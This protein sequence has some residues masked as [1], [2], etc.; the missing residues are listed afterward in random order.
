M[1]SVNVNAGG[2]VLQRELSFQTL[3]SLRRKTQ[4]VPSTSPPTALYV[5]LTKVLFDII[6]RT[7]RQDRSQPRRVK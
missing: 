1:T 2:Q 7:L 5:L 3:R 6:K 4:E